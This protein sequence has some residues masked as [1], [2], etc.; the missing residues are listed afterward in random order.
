MAERRMFAKSIVMDDKFLDLTPV[1]RCLYFALGMAADDDGFVG[2]VRRVTCNC[3]AN[4]A[5]LQDLIDAG[6]VRMFPS[7]VVK[8]V[9]WEI[10][11]QLRK[12]RYRPTM[13]TEEKAEE[14]RRKWT[15]QLTTS[16]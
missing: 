2:S 5:R 13:Y 7:G 15:E 4:K 12:D 9:H 14:D 11:N 16:N 6:Y 1:A 3:G 10:N 8:I